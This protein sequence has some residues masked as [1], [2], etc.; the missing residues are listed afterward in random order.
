MFYTK[1][2]YY[3]LPNKRII[4][5]LLCRNGEPDKESFSPFNG[6]N[7][8]IE[9]QMRGVV[10]SSLNSYDIVKNLV[11]ELSL[12]KLKGKKEYDEDSEIIIKDIYEN[13]LENIDDKYIERFVRNQLIGVKLLKGGGREIVEEGRKV[14]SLAVDKETGDV[15]MES[16]KQVSE[17]HYE[18]YDCEDR[19]NIKSK[20]PYLLKKLQNGSIE[21]GISLLSLFIARDRIV[22]YYQKTEINPRDLLA[23]R[24]MY[25]NGIGELTYRV[26]KDTANNTKKFIDAKNLVLGVNPFDKY[27]IAGIE[28]TRCVRLLGYNLYEEDIDTYSPVFINNLVCKYIVSNQELLS[29][30]GKNDP[31]IIEMFKNK[32]IF[33]TISINTNKYEECVID[34]KDNNNIKMRKMAA[35]KASLSIKIS[36]IMI[37]EEKIKI[38]QN[39]YTL[40][41]SFFEFYH[42]EGRKPDHSIETLKGYNAI[43]GVICDSSNQPIIINGTAYVNGF[44]C[45]PNFNGVYFIVTIDGYLIKIDNDVDKSVVTT[46]L[47]LVRMKVSEFNYDVVKKVIKL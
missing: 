17:K 2:S 6:Y 23:N 21:Y 31:K 18:L 27:Y 1:G 30:I 37:K 20:I 22:N 3:Y 10:F 11:T 13:K 35:I 42:K 9:E 7:Y 47:D 46:V 29:D 39:I 26:D 5:D 25:V 41:N 36:N 32:S 14:Q 34:T 15:Y 8:L 12:S 19:E 44:G 4:D 43:N 28:L 45:T 24:I 33:S 38:D 40:L 16:E